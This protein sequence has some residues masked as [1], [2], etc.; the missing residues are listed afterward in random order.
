MESFASSAAYATTAP[1]VTV[2]PELEAMKPRVSAA[3]TDVNNIGP[4]LPTAP[5][6]RPRVSPCVKQAEPGPER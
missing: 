4:P 6:D 1:K 3:R 2:G 5:P